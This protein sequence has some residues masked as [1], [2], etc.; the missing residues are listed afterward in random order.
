[1]SVAEIKKGIAAFLGSLLT[2]GY[3]VVESDI[4]SIS[5]EEW[6]GLA[7]VVIT[8]VTVYFLKNKEPADG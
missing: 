7:G 2:W 6:L 3:M 1:M 8:T 5:A 4:D